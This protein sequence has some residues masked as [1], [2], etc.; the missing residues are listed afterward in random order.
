MN[1]YH[2][3]IEVLFLTLINICGFT[4]FQ[5]VYF[6]QC[7]DKLQLKADCLLKSSK[8][9]RKI[10]FNY[11]SLVLSDGVHQSIDFFEGR[12]K[13]DDKTYI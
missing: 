9:Q 6:Y 10:F 2:F 8:F 11:F 7:D 5:N 3:S 12:D 1:K 13:T 4:L